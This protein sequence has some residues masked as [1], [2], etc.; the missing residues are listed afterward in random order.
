[1]PPR[2]DFRFGKKRKDESAKG[3]HGPTDKKSKTAL[4]SKEVTLGRLSAT[5]MHEF[6]SSAK[7]AVVNR[8][9]DLRSLK[10][11]RSRADIMYFTQV[12]DISGGSTTQH[13]PRTS[14]S[15]VSPLGPKDKGVR[16]G[17]HT[18]QGTRPQT[19]GYAK[20][21]GRGGLGG[22]HH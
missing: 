22:S 11:D 1:M 16:I 15:D 2:E 6:P 13:A 17:G 8:L 7:R 14:G 18:P 4:L 19:E 10:E 21:G 20:S 3:S 9:Q 5:P 12:V